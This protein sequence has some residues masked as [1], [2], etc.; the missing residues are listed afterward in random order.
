MNVFKFGGAS[1][2]STSAIKNLLH[3]VSQYKGELVVVI[4]AFGKTTNK[5]EQLL[6][7]YINSSH[8]TFAVFE[9]LKSE[10]LEVCKELGLKKSMDFEGVNRI[11]DDLKSFL[12]LP[13]NGLYDF[14]YDQIVHVGELLSTTIIS[15]YLNEN[16]LLNQWID[17]RKVFKTDSTYREAN[18]DFD[19]TGRLC[20]EF[21]DFSVNKLYITQGFI[22]ADEKGFAVTLGREGSDYSAAILANLLNAE[23]LTIWK[24]VSGVLNADPKIYPNAE[25]LPELSYLEAVELA[26]SGAQVIHPK[27]IKPL[28]NKQIPLLVKSFVHPNEEGT[29]IRSDEVDKALLPIYILKTNQV[30]ITIKPKDYSFVLEECISNLF[31]KFFANRMKVNLIQTSAISFSVCVDNDERKLPLLLE[32]FKAHYHVLYNKD[33]QLMTIRHYTKEFVES[34]VKNMTV[35]VEQKSR[36]TIRLVVKA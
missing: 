31:A 6:D 3:L 27:T 24:D 29:I 28:Q 14:T 18:V 4:S 32:A 10:H 8:D 2:K 1:V 12:D 25:K 9:S 36:S 35:Y 33:V 16:G 5:L 26:Y 34:L 19:T 15:A 11:L 20:K 13:Y 21:F 23:S 30:L 7:S 22:G 17:I